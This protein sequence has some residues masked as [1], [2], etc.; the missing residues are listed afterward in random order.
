L[1]LIKIILVYSAVNNDRFLDYLDKMDDL[2]Q[3][4]I[5]FKESRMI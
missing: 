4:Q 2:E 5:K 1:L 3:K